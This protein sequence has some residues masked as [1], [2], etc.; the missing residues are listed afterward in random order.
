MVLKVVPCRVG[1]RPTVV[2]CDPNI[3]VDLMEKRSNKYSSRPRFVVMGEMYAKSSVLV[4]PYGK[5][6]SL[7]R[8]LLHRALTP[9]ALRTYHARQEAESTRLAFQVM[10]N[11][12]N[13]EREFDRFTASVVFSISYGHRIDSFDAPIIRQRLEFMQFMASLN[14]PG[15]Y[16]AESFPLLRHIPSFLAPWK[17][18]ILE[19][20]RLEADANMALVEGVKRDL[21]AGQEKGIAVAPSLTRKDDY[22]AKRAPF[23]EILSLE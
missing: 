14:V 4:Q 12:D 23:L 10:A 21:R 15:A 1:R 17:R 9:A 5:D 3:A 20:A 13:W 18:T 2:I 6:W 8:K 7:R 22:V 11:P 16:L 19:K